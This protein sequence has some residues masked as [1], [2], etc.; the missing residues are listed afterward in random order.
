MVHA[1]SELQRSMIDFGVTVAFALMG[2][3]AI[4]SIVACAR[5]FVGRL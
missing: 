5:V 1:I 2:V 3:F 4:M